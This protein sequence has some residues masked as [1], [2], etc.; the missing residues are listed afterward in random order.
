MQS[1][2]H[3]DKGEC[4]LSVCCQQTCIS[5]GGGRKTPGDDENFFSSMK[6]HQLKEIRLR[7]II[8]ICYNSI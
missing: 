4:S 5:M 6:Y 7:S 1:A 2:V 3:T 8:P